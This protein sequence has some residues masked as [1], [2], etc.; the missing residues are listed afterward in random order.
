VN[1]GIRLFE[2]KVFIAF[3]ALTF[4]VSGQALSHGGGLN[5]KGCHN[6][7][8]TNSY[9][10]HNDKTKKKRRSSSARRKFHKSNPCPSTGKTSGS[11]PG[12]HV[13][14][15]MPLACGGADAPH[16]MQWLTA[17]ANLSKGSMGCSY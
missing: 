12:Y 16:N 1:I 8:A 3:F 10:C 2:M 5:S 9:H 17:R 6:Q 15:V 13:D 14:H 4:I 7:S 11:C